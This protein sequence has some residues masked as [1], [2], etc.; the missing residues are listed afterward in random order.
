MN[1]EER[2]AA[3]L[4]LQELARAAGDIIAELVSGS[5]VDTQI[6]SMEEQFE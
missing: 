6:A 1:D 2:A 5:Y 4:E 3:V